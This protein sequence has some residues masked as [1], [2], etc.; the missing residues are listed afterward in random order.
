MEIAPLGI[1]IN[2]L[3]KSLLK[4][5]LVAAAAEANRLFELVVLVIEELS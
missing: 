1:G 3:N 5:C 4:R 2:Q